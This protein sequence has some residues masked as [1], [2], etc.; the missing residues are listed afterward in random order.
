MSR[1]APSLSPKALPRRSRIWRCAPWV[2]GSDG[3]DLRR[4][5]G[6]GVSTRL[7]T[8]VRGLCPRTPGPHQRWDPI[9]LE[10]HELPPALQRLVQGLRL[11]AGSALPQAIDCDAKMAALGESDPN[12]HRRRPGP[13]CEWKHGEG[14]GGLKAVVVRSGSGFT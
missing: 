4:Q 12:M 6:G 8:P 9:C 2:P 5:R 1:V 11:A 13:E 10:L 7:Q 3:E 14:C